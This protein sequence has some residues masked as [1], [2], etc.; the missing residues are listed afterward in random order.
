MLL[1]TNFLNAEDLLDRFIDEQILIEN[2]LGDSN[3]SSAYK[4][5]LQKNQEEDFRLFLTNYAANKQTHLAQPDPYIPEMKRVKSSIRI[6]NLKGNALAILRDEVKLSNLEQRE[7]MRNALHET[8]KETGADS[9]ELFLHQL[10]AILLKYL[11]DIKQLPEQKYQF[12]QSEI[13]ASTVLQALQ[14]ELEAN[15][16]LGNVVNSLS[17]ELVKN[18]TVIYN[19]AKLSDIKLFAFINDFKITALGQKL[20]NLL[21]PFD[22]DLTRLILLLLLIALVVIAE[23]ILK[24]VLNRILLHTLQ[25]Q[26]DVDYIHRQITRLFS[27]FTT[28]LIIQL[29]I[30]IYF[31]FGSASWLTKF[32]LIIY[33]V[34]AGVFFYRLINTIASLKIG[35][36]ENT[37]I[38]RKEVVNLLIK[39]INATILLLTVM[40]VLKILGADLTTLLGGLGIG[41]VA[42]AF[43]AKDSIA[44]IFGS[45]SILAGDIFQQ[46]D[47]IESGTVNGTVVEIG[48]RATTVRTFDN[49]LISLPNFELANTSVKNWSRRSIGRQ[50]KMKIGITYES[51]F[52]AIRKAINEIRQMIETHQGI[53]NENTSF[54]NLSRGAKLVSIE[55]FA[56]IKRTT[57]VYLDEFADSSINIMIQCFSHSVDMGEWIKVKEDVMYRVADIINSNGLEFAYPSLTLHQSKS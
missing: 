56:G 19:T 57:M 30:L 41:G 14:E 17:S 32:F 22:I 34:L 36:F 31:D 28:V 3:I 9:R 51:D 13:Q 5:N 26:N 52:D 23:K 45:I 18:S 53:A 10:S 27:L 25:N 40:V 15:S 44:N 49:A 43:A 20:D 12:D 42:V 1:F 50:I 37:K 39:V 24:Y 11:T 46:G 6:N 55:D 35:R 38:L 4:I 21:E 47:W 29:L 2:K 48:L 54:K 16:L 8:L 33:T 7:Q